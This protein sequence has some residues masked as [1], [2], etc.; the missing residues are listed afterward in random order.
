MSKPAG[1]GVLVA[2]LAVPIAMVL[3]PL[4]ASADVPVIPVPD[5]HAAGAGVANESG[6]AVA[7]YLPVGDAVPDEVEI[8]DEDFGTEDVFAAD[9]FIQTGGGVTVVDDPYV[10]YESEDLPVEVSD[11]AEATEID[12]IDEPEA[13]EVETPEVD[14]VEAPEVDEVEANE[15]EPTAMVGDFDTGDAE[16]SWGDGGTAVSYEDTSAYAGEDGAWVSDTESGAMSDDG[17]LSHSAETAA[18]HEE[19]NAAAGSDG[20]QVEMISSGTMTGG[21]GPNWTAGDDEF[22]GTL[23]DYEHTTAQAGSDGAWVSDV[24]SSAG[25]L[26]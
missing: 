7:Q 1:R 20:A 23:A 22:D 24:E 14:E 2:A 16:V 9:E 19:T 18:W 26:D 6:A 13:T 25:D 15:V 10:S 8:A 5:D 21:D 11:D 4:T 12:E 17:N 3:A